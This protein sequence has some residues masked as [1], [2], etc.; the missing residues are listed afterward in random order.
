MI[1]SLPVQ[2]ARQRALLQQPMRRVAHRRL[3]GVRIEV[4][5]RQLHHAQVGAD[6][7]VLVDIVARELPHDHA[8]LRLRPGGLEQQVLL[9]VAVA[10]T[11]Q[12][13]TGIPVAAAKW[14]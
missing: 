6:I 14:S 12:A 1:A 10:P 9:Q 13:E 8:G 5:A 4:G 11:P 7:D 2:E 3:A